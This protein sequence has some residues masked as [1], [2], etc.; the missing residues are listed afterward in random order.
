MHGLIAVPRYNPWCDKEDRI[1]REAVSTGATDAKIARCLTEAGFTRTPDGVSYRR[2]T[3]LQIVR[4]NPTHV[5]VRA[6]RV[7]LE[8]VRLGWS[9]NGIANHIAGRVG[10]SF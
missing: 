9:N 5:D 8:K 10:R 7:I 2:R 4:P 6:R 3:A 1:L